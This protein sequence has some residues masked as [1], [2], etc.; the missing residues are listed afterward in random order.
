MLSSRN[1]SAPVDRFHHA[2]LDIAAEVE[3]AE[4]QLTASHRTAHDRWKQ[5]CAS[6]CLPRPL[7]LQSRPG[8]GARGEGR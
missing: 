7:P 2:L 6:P 4:A 3:A 8:R 5:S 1:T